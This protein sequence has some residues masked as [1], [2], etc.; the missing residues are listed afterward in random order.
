MLL[1][2]NVKSKNNLIYVMFPT[3]SKTRDIFLRIAGKNGSF[4]NIFLWQNKEQS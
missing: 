2:S 4:Y 3:T 1:F